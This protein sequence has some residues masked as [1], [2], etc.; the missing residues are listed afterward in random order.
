MIENFP[1]LKNTSSFRLCEPSIF[2]TGQIK[3]NSIL[4][5]INHSEIQGENKRSYEWTEKTG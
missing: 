1:E 4:K 5:Y 2:K 3:R